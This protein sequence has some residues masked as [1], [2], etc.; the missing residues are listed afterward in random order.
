MKEEE[1]SS[2][3]KIEA[4]LKRL[5]EMENNY[6]T[7]LENEKKKLEELKKHAKN[8][9][10]QKERI[11]KLKTS[12]A[13]KPKERNTLEEKLNT[14][15]TLDELNEHEAELKRK[16][17]EDQRII[18]DENTSASKR[19]AAE[20]RVAEINEELARLQTQ[21]EEREGALPLRE[22]VKNIFK[23]YG[24]TVLSITLAAGA[25]ITAI[26]NALVTIRLSL[27]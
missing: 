1:D 10:K 19:Q 15:K 2:N 7:N 16:N 25:V 6:Q 23:K 26:Y 17:E 21:I 18:D 4:K 3:V 11:D 14:T 13:A 20:E 12:L 22:R 5:Q 9:T 27:A 8:T 24:V